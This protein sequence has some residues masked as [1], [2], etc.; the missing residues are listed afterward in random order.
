M[1]DYVIGESVECSDSGKEWK[2]GTVTSVNT[3]KISR[4]QWDELI[5]ISVNRIDKY[6]CKNNHRGT[7]RIYLSICEKK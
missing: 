3:Q 2:C 5:N 1:E 7:G 4:R 6:F